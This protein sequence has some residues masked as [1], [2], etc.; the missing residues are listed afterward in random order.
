MKVNVLLYN[1]SQLIHVLKL[2]HDAASIC[3]INIMDFSYRDQP[4]ML[5]LPIMLCS[6]AQIFDLLYNYAHVKD[7]CLNF[8]CFIR[9]YSL[10][11]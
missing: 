1:H 5:I 4:I 8:D 7:L 9:V 11:S 2:P 6:G 10:V 3:L